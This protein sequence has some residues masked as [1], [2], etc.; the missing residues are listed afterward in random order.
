MKMILLLLT[1]LLPHLTTAISPDDKCDQTCLTCS[2][3]YPVR[4]VPCNPDTNAH[5]RGFSLAPTTSKSVGLSNIK[6]TSTLV[7]GCVGWNALTNDMEVIAPCSANTGTTNWVN[8]SLVDC[9]QFNISQQHSKSGSSVVQAGPKC[10][11]NEVKLN[12]CLDIKSKV[13]PVL[14]LTHCYNQPND[15][16]T[17]SSSSSSSGVAQDDG[18]WSSEEQLPT[19]PQRCMQVDKQ[20]CTRAGCCTSCPPGRHLTPE[21]FCML[22]DV[23]L[24]PI[25]RRRKVYIFLAITSNA[26]AV[27]AAITELKKHRSSFT[28]I[29]F[30]YLSICGANNND[31]NRCAIKDAVGPAHLAPGNMGGNDPGSMALAGTLPLRLRKAL[32]NHLGKLLFFWLE[33]STIYST[34]KVCIL[35]ILH[36]CITFDSS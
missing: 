28:G 26:T 20:I 25:Q 7:D 27:D 8:S 30:Q 23:P 2:S 11:S 1:T 9:Q 36:I 10:Y 12:G 31:L 32:G 33:P 5:Q 6:Y 13:G 16:F 29:V 35:S 17:F 14:Q 21:G 19:Y 18:V 24:N 22:D 3:R 4:A 15:K 34:P